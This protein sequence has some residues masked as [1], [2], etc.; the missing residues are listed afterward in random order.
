MGCIEEIQVSD[1][2]RWNNTVKSIKGYDVFYLNEYVDAFMREDESNG[3]PV[4]LYYENG[5]D[6]AVNVVFKRDVSKDHHFVGKLETDTYFDLITPYGYGGFLGEISDYDSLNNAYSQYCMDN[7]YVCEFVRF[8]LFSDYYQQYEG[9]IESRTHNVVRNLE[10]SMDEIW[11]DFKQKVRKNVKRANTYGVEVIIDEPGTYMDDFLRIYYG[12]MERSDAE[13]QFYFKKPFFEE[14][15]SMENAVMFHVRFEEK[16]ISTEL[17]IYGAENCYSYL[18][19]TDSEYFYTRANDFLKFEIIKW[20]KEK[21]LKN[22]VLGGGYGSDDGIFQ[23]KMNL[24]P[25]GIKD[26]YIGRKIFDNVAYQQLLNIRSKGNTDM[27]DKLINTG[28]FPAYRGG[29][30]EE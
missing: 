3:V 24:A 7:R 8:E 11:M 5:D 6:R 21:G 2:V 17:V 12:T 15:M 13:N 28:F 26:F 25:H 19:G 16:I 29:E 23:Y 22:F 20:A 30:Q 14:L 4:L 9:E 10:S 18:G 1:R 27:G